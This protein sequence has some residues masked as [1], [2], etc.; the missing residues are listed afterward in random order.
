MSDFAPMLRHFPA[1]SVLIAIRASLNEPPAPRWIRAQCDP[2]FGG[3]PTLA[4]AWAG[5]RGVSW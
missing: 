4:S 3:D 5:V 1:S 2:W